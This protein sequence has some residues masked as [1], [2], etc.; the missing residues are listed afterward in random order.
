MGHDEFLINSVK[1]AFVWERRH[2]SV[3]LEQ[4]ICNQQVVGSNPTAGSSNFRFGDLR[5]DQLSTARA[6]RQL[7]FC[8]DTFRSFEARAPVNQSTDHNKPERT[9]DNL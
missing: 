6:K 8:F 2:S 4:L 5:F 7:K 3:G 9:A 1:T